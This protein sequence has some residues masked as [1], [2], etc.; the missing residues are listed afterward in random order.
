MSLQGT[1]QIMHSAWTLNTSNNAWCMETEH[2]Y[3]HVIVVVADIIIIIIIITTT[4][5]IKHLQLNPNKVPTKAAILWGITTLVLFLPNLCNLGRH[6]SRY[7]NYHPP[8]PQHTH[9]CACTHA[10][11]HACTH[12]LTHTHTH[13]HTHNTHTHTHTHTHKTTTKNLS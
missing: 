13:T 10:H 2:E 11:T 6:T 9:A 3:T 1:H 12:A 7:Q 8:T 4:I 5:I